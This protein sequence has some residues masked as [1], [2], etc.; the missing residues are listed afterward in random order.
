MQTKRNLNQ[1]NHLQ[2]KA[3][4]L[5]KRQKFQKQR[6]HLLQT[7]LINQKKGQR[8]KLKK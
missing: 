6:T 3:R 2:K 7:E 5:K 8:L 1:K 4:N